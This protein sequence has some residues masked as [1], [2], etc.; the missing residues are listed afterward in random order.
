[1]K[2]EED[3]LKKVDKKGSHYWLPHRIWG[4]EEINEVDF[5]HKTPMT[6]GDKFSHFFI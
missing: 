5:T 3:K 6:I 4:K 1:M 2:E